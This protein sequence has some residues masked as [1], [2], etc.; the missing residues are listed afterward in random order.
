MRFSALIL[1]ALLLLPAGCGLNRKDAD[2]KLLKACTAAAQ[3]ILGPDDTLEIQ[4]SDFS[5]EKDKGQTNLRKVHIA[6]QH[7]PNHGIIRDLDIDCAFEEVIGITGTSPRFYSMS[8]GPD[9]YGNFD[10]HYEG[11]M[12]M[13][14]Q[15][16]GLFDEKL[17]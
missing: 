1:V 12:N 2:A 7:A 16:N 6:A 9:K 17:K 4:K 13:L 3:M 11:D 15:L 10:G 5:T 8:V 14:L